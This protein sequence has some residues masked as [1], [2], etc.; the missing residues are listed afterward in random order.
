[1]S[2]GFSWLLVPPESL[3]IAREDFAPRTYVA[4]A[5]ESARTVR[6]VSEFGRNGFINGGVNRPATLAEICARIPE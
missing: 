6:H 1:M 3:L 4:D 5:S 2:I